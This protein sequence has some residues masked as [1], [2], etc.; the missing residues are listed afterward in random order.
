VR[1][2]IDEDV[3]VRVGSLLADSHEV[4]HARDVFG[5]QTEDVTNVAWARAQSAIL[6]TADGALAKKLRGSR[7]CGCLHLRDLRTHELD[8]VRELQAVVEAEAAVQG[9]RFWM[10]IGI[11]TYLVGR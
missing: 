5:V 2:L 4:D 11:D 7:Q 8:R 1:F 10:Q 6:V 9:E 3:D